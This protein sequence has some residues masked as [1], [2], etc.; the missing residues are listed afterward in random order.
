[1]KNE[2][3]IF[4]LL[5]FF[6]SICY[7]ESSEQFHLTWTDFF[8][9]CAYS[10]ED[11]NPVRCA[12]NF[13]VPNFHAEMIFNMF[14]QMLKSFFMLNEIIDFFDDPVGSTLEMG[15]NIL[16]GVRKVLFPD[17]SKL[18][19]E[20][21]GTI[22]VLSSLMEG[23][24]NWIFGVITPFL[25]IILILAFEFIKDYLILSIPFLLWIHVLKELSLIDESPS[26][27]WAFYLA[28]FVIILMFLGSI[29][30]LGSDLGLYKPLIIV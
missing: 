14:F 10:E 9:S 17:Y 12:C 3:K 11:Y 1:M 4:L 27:V 2:V 13:I 26:G 15:S 8:P 5:V 18:G 7:A 6:S 29:W 28:L 23:I 20:E 21:E 30:L 22:N 25:A 24:F 19:G 16:D